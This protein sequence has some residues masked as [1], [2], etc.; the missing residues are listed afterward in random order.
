MLGSVSSR[1]RAS[2]SLDAGAGE[3]MPNRVPMEIDFSDPSRR[4]AL[5][6]AAALITSA[7][8]ILAN[9]VGAPNPSDNAFLREAMICAEAGIVWQGDRGGID[10]IDPH[11][12]EEVEIKSTKLVERGSI[13]FPT[14]RGISPTVIARFRASG[15]WLFGVFDNFSNLA[16]VYRV[17]GR[18]MSP[19]IDILE[20]KMRARTAAGQPLENNPKTT[21]DSIRGACTVVFLSPD[22]EEYEI[23]PGRWRIR[24]K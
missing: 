18:D 20:Q 15:Y 6:K 16:V 23:A 22:F 9:E 5:K 12:L 3:R 10:A 1:A 8:E 14:S 19:K 24:S 4:G 2:A 17:D 7:Y 11:T 13:Q 21:L